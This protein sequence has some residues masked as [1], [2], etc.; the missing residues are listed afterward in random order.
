MERP[1]PTRRRIL[2]G[3]SALALPAPAAFAQS[4]PTR[5]ISLVV[6][7]AAGGGVDSVSRI[8]GEELAKTLGGN[9]VIEN[10]AG[11]GTVIGTQAVVGAA[12]DGH[13]LLAAPTTIVINPAV[14]TNLPYDWSTDLVPVALMAKLPFVAV[15]RPDFAAKSLKEVAAI[16]KSSEKPLNFASGGTGTV[17][18]LAGELFALRSGARMQHIPYRGEG[19]S[20][21]DVLGGRIEVTFATLAA[22]AA[23]VQAGTLRALAITTGERSPLL[24]NVPTVAEQGFDGYD[25]SAWIGVMAPKGTPAPIVARLREALESTLMQAPIRTKLTT[26]GSIPAPKGFDLDAFMKREAATWA[27]LVKD[28]NIKI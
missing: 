25:V 7:F 6:T 1:T 23:Q 15:C 26:I 5:P 28:A 12:P 10:R 27:K 8:V 16:S 3:L 14:R 2:A 21:V 19:P 22:V 17:A 4:Y 18:H 24:P 20:I 13:T 11:G 9:V